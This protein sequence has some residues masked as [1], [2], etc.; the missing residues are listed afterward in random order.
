MTLTFDESTHTY[1]YDGKKVPSVTHILRFLSREEY[2]EIDE[3]TLNAAADRGTKVHKAVEA[4]NNGI[5]AKVEA[6]I[7]PYIIAYNK[8][9]DDS[10]ATVIGSEIRLG[11][12]DYAGTVDALVEFG[13]G[14]YAL[15]DIKTA[16][17]VK[18]TLVKAQ[19]NAYR[20]LCQHCFIDTDNM[21]LLCIQLR[22]DGTY[23]QYGVAIGNDEFDACM[24]LHKAMERKHGRGK[25]E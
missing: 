13:E 24:T 22:K 16:E 2:G 25:I 3:S 12:P 1:E 11:C 5:E 9:L 4:I 8:W 17:S 20:K 19:L 7:M 6:A 15:I 23:M 18:K 14:Q 21:V 10:K